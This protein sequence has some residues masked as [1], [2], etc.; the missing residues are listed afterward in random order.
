MSPRYCG[1]RAGFSRCYADAMADLP[2]VLVV[3]A[4][5]R[6]GSRVLAQL[7]DRGLRVRA[8]VRAKAKVAPKLV[9]NPQLS[10]TEASLMALKNDD[11]I[12][13]VRG[14][15]A[16]ISCLGHVLTLKGILGRPRNLVTQAVKRV[17]GAIESLRPEKPVKIIVMTSVSVNR[18]E[19]ETRRGG[20]ERAFL[21]VL[22]GLV[23]P[24]K[25]NQSAADFL[26]RKIGASNSFVEWAVIRPDTLLEGPVT[27]YD[28]HENLINSVFS[29]GQ[30]NMANVAHFMCELATNA[31]TWAKWKGKLPVIVNANEAADRNA[32]ATPAH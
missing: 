18:R 20:I 5:G 10:L 27:K 17:C 1:A 6:T 9:Q 30:S 21:C 13:Q 8:I 28:L 11:W 3:G 25:D 23:P 26:C 14:C 2:S 29:P 22:R 19:R 7:L 12:E 16:V 24:A 31:E 4:T 32:C 15:D